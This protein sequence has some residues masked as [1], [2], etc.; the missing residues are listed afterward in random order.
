MELKFDEGE[1]DVCWPR[2][3]DFDVWWG[4]SIMHSYSLVI[5]DYWER[6]FLIQKNQV[7]KI[8][9]MAWMR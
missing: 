3:L 2:A 7:S 1:N 5:S 8:D 9:V 6:P 4:I